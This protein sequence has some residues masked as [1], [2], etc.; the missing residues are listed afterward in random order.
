LKIT[1]I[2]T[3]ILGTGS[4]KDLLFCRVETEDGIYGWGEA[5]VT[6]GKEGVVA[7]CI[8]A[9]APYVIGRSVFNIRHTGQV[10]FED[11]AIRRISLELM[12]AWSAIEIASWDI[13]GKRAGLPV[14]NLIGGPSRERVRVYA[15]GW[16]RG[17]T[18][19]E[20]VER[21]LKVKAMGFTA[22]NSTR[23]PAPGAAM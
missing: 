3:L 20:G 9:M 19:E 2:E 7:Q 22:A 18:I 12:A 17:T 6:A 13:I 11:F 14:Y 1:R 4:S 23:S 21:G 15:N 8:E 16:S 10:M 5:Y